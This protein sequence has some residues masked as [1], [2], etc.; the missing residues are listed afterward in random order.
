MKIRL[1]RIT[2]IE[3]KLHNSAKTVQKKRDM[4]IMNK[5]TNQ[6]QSTPMTND[7]K[8]TCIEKLLAKVPFSLMQW[9]LIINPSCVNRVDKDPLAVK[10]LQAAK[11]FQMASDSAWS[12]CRCMKFPTQPESFNDGAPLHWFL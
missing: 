9:I 11:L 1:I 6:N 5:S 2:A 3:T 7:E 8:N 10:I 4:Q 12:A